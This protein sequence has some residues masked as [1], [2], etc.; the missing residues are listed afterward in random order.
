MRWLRLPS[1]KDMTHFWAE[2]STVWRTDAGLVP[3]H[4]SDPKWL[5][6]AHPL[7][8]A[9]RRDQRRRHAV[10]FQPGRNLHPG[11]RRIGHLPGAI[12]RRNADGVCSA[13]SRRACA[14]KPAWS[15]HK[16]SGMESGQSSTS[17][18]T[19]GDQQIVSVTT[20]PT[21]WD[22]LRLRIASRIPADPEN[23]GSSPEDVASLG[24]RMWHRLEDQQS[25]SYGRV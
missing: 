2:F 21:A 20:T 11:Q 14:R 12:L 24:V 13:R 19:G 3:A 5:S 8:G 6:P 7:R 1:H 23:S 15:I 17:R 9:G 10:A 16:P 4:V 25:R 18:P 22:G